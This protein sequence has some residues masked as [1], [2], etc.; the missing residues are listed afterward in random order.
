MKKV[1]L[2]FLI[3]I[4]CYSFSALTITVSTNPVVVFPAVNPGENEYAGGYSYPMT[5]VDIQANLGSPWSLDIDAS[6]FSGPATLALNSLSWRVG[7]A[8]ETMNVSPWYNNSNN[9][10]GAWAHP[11][12]LHS[13]TNFTGLGSASVVSGYSSGT[14]GGRA[15][16]GFFWY[17]DVPINQQA[18]AYSSTITFTLTQ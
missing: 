8:D 3:I 13:K 18:G 4:S 14:F 7:Y 1:I 9:Q 11:E 12:W 16:L 5:A 15:S 2:L 10:N 17:L 6:A